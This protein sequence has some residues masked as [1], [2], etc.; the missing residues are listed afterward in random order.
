[1]SDLTQLEKDIMQL[2]IEGH[3]AREITDWLA[4]DY[5]QYKKSKN[6][7]LKE[8]KITR[9]TQILPAAINLGLFK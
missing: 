1:M 9:I 3:N 5:I 8:L 4:I 7:I 2:L 6:K